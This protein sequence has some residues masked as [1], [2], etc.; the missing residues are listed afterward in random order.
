MIR[1]N[2]SHAYYFSS[3]TTQYFSSLINQTYTIA[4]Q[5]S[6]DIYLFSDFA[7][8]NKSYSTFISKTTEI[9]DHHLVTLQ[10]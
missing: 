1:E 3:A 9:Y 7:C 2:Y 8:H 10:Q 5:N 6:E 4:R